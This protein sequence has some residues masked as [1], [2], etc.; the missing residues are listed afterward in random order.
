MIDNGNEKS[1]GIILFYCHVVTVTPKYYECWKTK[2]N[3]FTKR[4]AHICTAAHSISLS[5]KYKH[6]HTH[7]RISQ[8]NIL[9]WNELNSPVWSR[10]LHFSYKCANNNLYSGCIHE[11]NAIL[12][13]FSTLHSMHKTHEHAS[14]AIQLRIFIRKFRLNVR[15]F[16]F[17]FFFSGFVRVFVHQLLC[18]EI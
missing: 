10:R 17:F 18:K 9:I 7:T 1:P 4:I 15:Y 2:R 11:K 12:W 5:L 14:W 8:P 13:A 6:T 3:D 16:S